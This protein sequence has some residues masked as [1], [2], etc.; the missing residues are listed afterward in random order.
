[1]SEQTIG[2]E[3]STATAAGTTGAIGI[4]AGEI[5]RT[6]R[7]SAGIEIS[8]LSSA[9]K[10]S[11]KRIE[12]LEGNRFDLLPNAVFY[13]SLAASICK[14]LHV[15]AAPVLEKLPKNTAPQF[16]S[17]ISGIN[18]PF[19]VQGDLWHFTIPPFLTKPATWAVLALLVASLVILLLPEHKVAGVTQFLH[20][21]SAPTTAV[22]EVGNASTGSNSGVGDATAQPPM[23]TVAP[24]LTPLPSEP[25]K[26][27][28]PVTAMAASAP[29]AMPAS[30]PASAMVAA[31][32]TGLASSA[33]SAS[34]ASSAAAANVNGLIRFKA[35]GSVWIQVVDAN[36]KT[37]LSKALSA[38]EI[39]AASGATPLAVVVGRADLVDVE[40]RGAP[41]NVLSLA[42]EN[43]AKFE[44]K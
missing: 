19:R 20:K 13:R 25:E 16:E 6:A 38:G 42:K 35:K 5:L 30:R 31:S 11:E 1:M 36:G 41:F 22:E 44:V 29:P 24:P 34:A 18:Q 27:L 14:Y 39:A 2:G 23:V 32:A 33:S 4:T 12:A 9:L 40:V 8:T 7:E 28:P 43:I 10:V 15:D 21:A 37:Q 3:T 26:P 17:G